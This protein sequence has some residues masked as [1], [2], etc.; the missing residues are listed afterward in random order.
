MKNRKTTKMI[1]LLLILLLTSCSSYHSSR[2]EK[3]YVISLDRTPQRFAFVQKQLNAAG[4]RCTRFRAIDGYK[5]AFTDADKTV[6]KLQRNKNYTVS[7]NNRQIICLDTKNTTFSL[8]EIG[9]ACSHIEIWRKVANR[10]TD[11]AI[12]FEDDVILEKDFKKKMYKFL[13]DL[14]KDWDMAFLGVGRRR[15]KYGKYPCIGDIFRDLDNVVDHPYTAKIQPTNRVYG[16]YGYVINRKG[17][18][19][20]LKLVKTL[21]FP[22]DDVVFQ[23]GGVDTN[24]IKAYVSM[25][26]LLEPKLTDSEIKKMGRS[27]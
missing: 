16:M 8:G 22:I 2:S 27:Y 25:Y 9:C 3:A 26:K 17:A 18:I 5:L 7:Y 13:N 6:D 1:K 12:I 15:D 24:Y 21:D 19:K 23:Q 10:E 4:I 14:P 11:I 20:L